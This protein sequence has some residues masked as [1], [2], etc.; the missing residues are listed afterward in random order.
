MLHKDGVDT[1]LM[2]LLI[3]LEAKQEAAAFAAV[4]NAVRPA[5]VS[6]R[7]NDA[8]WRHALATLWAATGHA[9]PALQIWRELADSSTLSSSREDSQER[10]EAIEGAVGLLKN[11]KSCPAPLAISYLPWLLSTSPSDASQALIARVDLSPDQILPLLPMGEETRWRYLMHLVESGTSAT[12][13]ETSHAQVISTSALHTEFA[14]SLIAAIFEASPRLQRREGHRSDALVRH[15]TTPLAA[16]TLLPP[17]QISVAALVSGGRV[18]DPDIAAD[19]VEALRFRL[20]LHLEKS[21]FLEDN[22]KILDALQGSAL[23]EESA[24]VHW[25]MKDHHAT[26]RIL[27][28]TLRDVG[29]AVCYASAFLPESDHRLLLHL[30]LR[31][32]GGE[33]PRWEDACRVVAVLG[34]SLDPLEVV[35]AAPEDMPM[36]I[37]VALVAPLLRERMHRRRHGQMTTGLQKAKAAAEVAR[38]NAA[39]EQNVVIDEDKACPDCH[40]RIGGKVFVIVHHQ[41][42]DGDQLSKQINRNTDRVVHGNGSISHDRGKHGTQQSPIVVCLSCWNKRTTLAGQEKSSA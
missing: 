4:P 18:P 33:Q 6:D 30:L 27:A 42:K 37:A 32:G 20:R 34:S 17:S 40:L 39:E 21:Q 10:V 36:P 41:L 29:A 8:G 14:I 24:V 35:R 23:L 3:D 31:P 38:Q 2:H 16:A 7:L 26:L 13:L 9:E 1:L 12:S 22:A 5:L 19:F 28:V 11:P 15:S 25:R